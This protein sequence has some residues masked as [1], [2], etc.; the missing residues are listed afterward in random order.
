MNV[1]EPNKQEKIVITILIS[2]CVGFCLGAFSRSA[3][4]K[5]KDEKI[6]ELIDISDSLLNN[7]EFPNNTNHPLNFHK[8]E[9]DK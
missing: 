2:L 3:E 7:F 4:I 8:A 9:I 5:E 6:V 1:I